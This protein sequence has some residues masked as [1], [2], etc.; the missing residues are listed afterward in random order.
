MPFHLICSNNVLSKIN[1]AADFMYY[2]LYMCIYYYVYVNGT[3]TY[4]T[5]GIRKRVY[6]NAFINNVHLI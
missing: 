6:L 4:I 2:L 3:Y 5:L 1:T